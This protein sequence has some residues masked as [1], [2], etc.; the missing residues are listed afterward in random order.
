MPFAGAALAAPVRAE[1]M[2]RV[3]EVMGRAAEA[4]DAVGDD[5]VARV[6]RSEFQLEEL[7][8]ATVDRFLQ[9]F[10]SSLVWTDEGNCFNRAMWGAHRL[11]TTVGIGTSPLHDTFAGA[12]AIRHHMHA[13][14]DYTGGFHATLAVNVQGEG[15]M[16]ADLLPGSAELVP[17]AQWAKGREADT[18]LLRPWAGSGIE[19][20]AGGP[21]RS[22]YVTRPYFEWAEGELLKSWEKYTRVEAAAGA[23]DAAA[24]AADAVKGAA[25][26]LHGP[27]AKLLIAAGVL[28]AVGVGALMF[29]DR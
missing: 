2:G 22:E 27:A 15:V 6:A 7:P 29:K 8:R 18:F 1:S 26:G 4:A 21:K 5:A 13:G 23:A 14:P 10:R 25:N 11:N 28:G 24:G 16:V 20:Y 17:Y 12:I 19:V 9:D 3:H